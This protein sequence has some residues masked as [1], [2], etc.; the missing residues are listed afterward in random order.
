LSAFFLASSAFG[1][2]E[3]KRNRIDLGQWVHSV[4]IVV[5]FLF[6]V[7]D[8]FRG[9]IVHIVLRDFWVAAFASLTGV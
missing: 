1:H 7:V 2:D 4:H 6:I 3:K 8:G 5:L 9:D